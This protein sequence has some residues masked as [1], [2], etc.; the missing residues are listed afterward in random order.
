MVVAP[1]WVP[2]TPT[3]VCDSGVPAVVAGT[4][5][6]FPGAEAGTAV[7]V[8]AVS[9][10]VVAGWLEGLEGREGDNDAVCE[11]SPV[12]F[13]DLPLQAVWTV[14]APYRE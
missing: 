13:S 5:S 8:T 11:S 2:A 12:P 14:G 4:S 3:T 7:V 1:A 9:A 10:V 6:S